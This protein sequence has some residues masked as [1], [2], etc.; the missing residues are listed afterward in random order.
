MLT[1]IKYRDLS[2]NYNHILLTVRHYANVRNKDLDW[3]SVFDPRTPRKKALNI[4]KK[5]LMGSIEGSYT[6]TK[7]SPEYKAILALKEDEKLSTRRLC[8]LIMQHRIDEQ[9]LW[10]VIKEAGNS[11]LA[12]VIIPLRIEEQNTQQSRKKRKQL[13]KISPQN[14]DPIQKVLKKLQNGEVDAEA[15]QKSS[16]FSSYESQD[17]RNTS[18]SQSENSRNIDVRCLEHYL[19]KAEQHESQRRKYAWEQAK[20]YNWEQNYQGPENLSA[21]QILFTASGDKRARKGLIGRLASLF[22][23]P[24]V[25]DSQRST[26]DESKELLVYEL[27]TKTE[28]IAPLSNDNSLFN[29]NYKDLFGIINSSGSAPEEILSVINRF[30]NK[31]WKLVGDLYDQSQSIVFQR[32]ASSASPLK[33]DKSF[34]RNTWLLTSIVVALIY[35][36]YEFQS[37]IGRVK[38]H[39]RSSASS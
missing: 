32:Q 23:S 5:N 30:E 36:S 38:D 33:A 31:G 28:R 18:R 15:S 10:E 26:D 35:G 25:P 22:S 19:Q 29:I 34:K 7:N 37:S 6:P 39:P 11:H 9:R 16:I 1:I 8:E 20:K 12:N 17:D 21:G 4:F 2:R 13:L 24:S 14:R 3:S 27:T